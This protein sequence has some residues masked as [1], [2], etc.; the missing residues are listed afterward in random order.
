MNS[1]CDDISVFVELQNEFSLTI[2]NV[3]LGLE[4]FRKMFQSYFLT[5]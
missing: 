5:T 4:V 3:I 2:C 1:V